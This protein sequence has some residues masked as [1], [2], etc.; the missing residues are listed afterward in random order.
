V[1]AFHKKSKSG[2]ATPEPN[3]K[4]IEKQLTAVLARHGA[5]GRS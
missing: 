2:I 4:W 5:S 3:V 1:H